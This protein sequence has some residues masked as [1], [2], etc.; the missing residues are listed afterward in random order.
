[1]TM[2]IGFAGDRV[3][4]ISSN[5]GLTRSGRVG[6]SPPAM[7]KTRSQLRRLH[8]IASYPYLPTCLPNMA[9]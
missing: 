9:A 3:R 1:M 7:T 2:L 8:Q 5:D 4:E 6:V